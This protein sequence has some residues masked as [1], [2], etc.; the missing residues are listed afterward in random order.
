VLCAVGAA[1]MTGRLRQP[2]PVG[3]AAR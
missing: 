1:V 2:Q 3:L